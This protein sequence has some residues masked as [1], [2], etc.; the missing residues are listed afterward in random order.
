LQRLPSVARKRGEHRE[1]YLSGRPLACVGVEVAAHAAPHERGVGQEW[2]VARH[3]EM[4]AHDERGLVDADGFGRG[5]Q[6]E[7]QGFKMLLR[8]A[9]SHGSILLGKTV[10]PIVFGTASVWVLA[11]NRNT[12]NPTDT[13]GRELSCS[14]RFRR[15]L[16]HFGRHR[17]AIDDNLDE[18]GFFE[19]CGTGQG[20]R[21]TGICALKSPPPKTIFFCRDSLC[22]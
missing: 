18:L 3:I 10:T 11:H 12:Q 19:E 16:F 21:Y 1:A 6:R 4:L 15:E 14:A 9:L 13:S 8:R 5:G 17:N 20:K 2:T 7:L 22:C